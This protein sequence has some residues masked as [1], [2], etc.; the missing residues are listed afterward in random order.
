[1]TTILYYHNPNANNLGHFDDSGPSH[2]ELSP[3]QLSTL[4][5]A[6]HCLW[7][8]HNLDELP[9]DLKELGAI[10]QV[11][12]Q[13]LWCGSFMP[14]A[15]V[16]FDSGFVHQRCAAPAQLHRRTHRILDQWITTNIATITPHSWGWHDWEWAPGTSQYVHPHVLKALAG[17]LFEQPIDPTNQE[18]RIAVEAAGFNAT[19]GAYNPEA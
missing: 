17:L 8:K 2:K 13:C 10:I 18:L 19:T 15:E 12:E 6:L 5:D 16:P 14:Q 11:G 9:E 4:Q 3:N 7:D 1:M